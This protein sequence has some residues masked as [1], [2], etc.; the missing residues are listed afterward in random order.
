[1]VA[2]ARRPVG[3]MATL[4]CSMSERVEVQPVNTVHLLGRVGAAPQ[5]RDLPSGDT[6][7]QFRVVV[8]RPK[9]R[10]G[11]R[12]ARSTVDTIDVTCWSARSRGSALRLAE[13]DTV[14]VQGSL[15][16]RFFAAAA[17]RVSR[18]E[19]EAALVRRH[20]GAPKV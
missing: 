20:R 5:T 13:G 7:V 8:P 3:P 9:A 4:G 16:R 12:T 17:G 14:E 18:Y 1:M 10:R 19:V 2:V 6:L 11:E 15:R